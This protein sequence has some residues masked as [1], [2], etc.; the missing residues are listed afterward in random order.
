[1]VPADSPLACIRCA[2]AI[3][4]WSSAW[5]DRWTARVP[6]EPYGLLRD[7]PGKLQ[8]QFGKARQNAGHH[9][10]RRV[11]AHGQDCKA[12]YAGSNPVTRSYDC[13]QSISTY[14]GCFTT[15]AGGRDFIPV[16]WYRDVTTRVG[17]YRRLVRTGCV[18]QGMSANTV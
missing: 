3:F 5:A 9:P 15:L 10:T 2:R 17:C 4:G 11:D 7:V 8:L 16:F 13:L 14:V 1:M 18:P 6:G 12:V